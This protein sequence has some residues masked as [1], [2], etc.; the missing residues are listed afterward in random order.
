MLDRRGLARL[1]GCLVSAQ[2]ASD[3]DRA[4]DP[5][6]WAVVLPALRKV[7]HPYLLVG[8]S[9]SAICR[10]NGSSPVRPII[11]VHLACTAGSAIGLANPRSRSGYGDRLNAL[12]GAIRKSGEGRGLPT[13]LQF[14]Q[15]DIEFVFTYRRIAAKRARFDRDE[16]DEFCHRV[17]AS[18]GGFLDTCFDIPGPVRLLSVLP[19]ALSDAAWAEG[20]VDSHVEVVEE[21]FGPEA[22]RS[23]QIPSWAERTALH[24]A[25]NDRLA[26]L[27]A[28][29]QMTFVDLCRCL[30]AG[31]PVV[32]EA[33]I[34][35]SGGRDHHLDIAAAQARLRSLV[36]RNVRDAYRAGK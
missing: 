25:F 19:P 3:P 4:R 15:V 7:G 26:A 6:F 27:C 21:G 31:R 1:A 17:A 28:D 30:L 11:P 10:I 20:Y 12:A 24:V 2:L 33:L 22:V 14:G 8:D 32:D 16:Y 36:E 23:L 18:Y 35:L 9:H 5:S 13:L 29:R 34:T